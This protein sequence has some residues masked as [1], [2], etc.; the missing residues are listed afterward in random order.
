MSG[1]RMSGQRSITTM[2]TAMV[3]VTAIP[4][5]ALHNPERR[6]SVRAADL[7][8]LPIPVSSCDRSIDVANQ[9]K[10]RGEALARSISL[11]LA[12]P[13]RRPRGHW[14]IVHRE[15]PRFGQA[16]LGTNDRKLTYPV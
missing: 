8:R 10:P 15:I 11:L 4:P 16:D 5:K 6:L 7:A 9:H 12:A 2:P 13:G 14:F 1:Q 3:S